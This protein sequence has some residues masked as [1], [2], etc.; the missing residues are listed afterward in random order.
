MAL[1][2]LD[3]V[4]RRAFEEKYT[5]NSIPTHQNLIDFIVEL[6]RREELL[7][8][9]T[10]S[11]TRSKEQPPR[12][13]SSPKSE[14][15]QPVDFNPDEWATRMK[16]LEEIHH[17]VETHLLKASTDQGRRYNLRRRPEK[18]RIGDQVLRLS[19]NLSS[20]EDRSA[21]KLCHKYEGPFTVLSV[22]PAGTCKLQDS[23]GKDAG[24]WHPSKL[25]PY[26][27]STA[28]GGCVA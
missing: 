2:H 26:Y 12:N 14:I 3:P 10:V 9:V 23:H 22:S 11:S 20:A 8:P 1:S 28:G 4:T 25:K 16:K 15:S 19:Y 6:S 17:L 5:S 21:A 13:S 24:L 18:F 27:T 7:K